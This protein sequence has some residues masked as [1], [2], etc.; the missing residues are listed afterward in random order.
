VSLATPALTKG[1]AERSG[2][3]ADLLSALPS[4]A[5]IALLQNIDVIIL[6]RDDPH[7]SGAYAAISVISKAVVFAA[8]ALGGYLLPEA[9]IRWHQGHHALRQLAVALML[10]ALPALALLVAVAVAPHLLLS[11]VFSA[12]YAGASGALLALVLAMM[13]LSITVTLTMYLLAVG[14]RWIVGVLLAGT[15]AA[16]VAVAAAHGRPGATAHADLAVQ[17]AL[18]LAVSIGFVAVHWR[19]LQ[20]RRPA[21]A[22]R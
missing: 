8:V 9:A 17:A 2:I 21:G 15:A 16:A 10:L 14:C 6:V 13:C 22:D 11:L 12:R 1:P 20:N 5:L 7:A 4:L 18:A 19:R 3:A